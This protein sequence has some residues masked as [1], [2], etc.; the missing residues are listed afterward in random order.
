MLPHFSP[1]LTIPFLLL[2]FITILSIKDRTI[3]PIILGG[4]FGFLLDANTFSKFPVFTIAFIAVAAI[5]KLFFARFVSYGEFR[6]TFVLTLIGL[7]IIYGFEV[8]AQLSSLTWSFGWLIP[9]IFNFLLTY[10]VLVLFIY[11][12]RKYFDWVEKSTEERFR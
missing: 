7:A 4:I 5:S 3:F 8:P 1:W 9:I 2:P 12:L 10:F 6:A 11:I